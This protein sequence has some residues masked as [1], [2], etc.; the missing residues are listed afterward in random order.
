MKRIVTL[1]SISLLVLSVSLVAAQQITVSQGQILT[2]HVSVYKPAGIPFPSGGAGLKAFLYKP[3]TSGWTTYSESTYK[4]L[5]WGN[6][7]RQEN[8]SLTITVGEGEPVGETLYLRVRLY[9]DDNSVYA[10]S[11]IMVTMTAVEVNGERTDLSVG[12]TCSGA[13]IFSTGEQ[14][15]PY[16]HSAF[17]FYAVDAAISDVLVV[18]EVEAP[19]PT[20]GIIIV[21]VLVL[22]IVA[23]V[24]LHWRKHGAEETF[25]TGFPTAQAHPPQEAVVSVPPPAEV[26]KWHLYLNN[27]KHGP[28]SA[29]DLGR[30]IDEGRVNKDTL[31][32][33]KGM[34]GWK[35]L[36]EIEEFK[37]RFEKS[38]AS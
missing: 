21:A 27:K 18:T 22:S 38:L 6:E 7:E 14:G 10:G 24:A 26:R 2:V 9:L 11:G 34:G 12:S 28:Y 19:L 31:V 20:W 29:A 37:S 13:E 30:Y 25:A 17:N 3:T 8:F 5:D 32:W 36:S 16:W 1:I 35:K 4:T 23:V 15:I 33:S